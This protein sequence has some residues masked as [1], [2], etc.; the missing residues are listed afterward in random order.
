MCPAS[1]DNRKATVAATWSGSANFA[2]GLALDDRVDASE[3]GAGRANQLG[4]R[5]GICQV[6]AAPRDPGAGTLTVRGHCFQALE[7]CRVGPLPMQ[8]QALVPGRQPARDRGSDP[9]PASGDD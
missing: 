7:P 8:H 6:T 4:C 9:D 3:R 5:S 2:S 1:G